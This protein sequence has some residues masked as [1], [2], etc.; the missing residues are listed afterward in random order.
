MDMRQRRRSAV[1]YKLKTISTSGIDGALS[2]AQLYRYLNE[3]EESESICLDILAADPENQAAKR[4]LGLAITDQFRG[5]AADRYP[6]AEAT[7]KALSDPYK[8]EYYLG[9]LCERRAK[10]QSRAGRPSHVWVPLFEEAMK[11]FATA[12]T[13]KPSDN[14]EA[15]LRWNRCVRLLQTIPPKTGEES[16]SFE[17]NDTS[18]LELARPFGKSAR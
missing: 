10:A 13:I 15:V 11:H 6:E 7:F 9:I 8:R 1:E 14:E 3:P 4:L 16:V 17:D 5:V 2:K 12:E 18:P